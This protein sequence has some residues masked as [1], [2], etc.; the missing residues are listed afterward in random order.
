MLRRHRPQ[1]PASSTRRHL[2]GR[3]TP[4]V[5]A[6]ALALLT[7]CGGGAAVD[8]NNQTGQPNNSGSNS[9]PDPTSPPPETTAR[10]SDPTAWANNTVP[11][12]GQNVLI[13]TGTSM[14]LDVDT[15]ALGSLALEGALVVGDNQ[16]VAITAADVEIRDGGLLQIGSSAEPHTHRATITLT[17]ARGVHVPRSEDN[18]LDND[19]TARGLRVRD[20]GALI[21]V[22]DAPN[23]TK[24]KLN[25]HAN[26]G[27]TTFTLADNVHWRAGDQVAISVT[28]FYGVGETEVL[29]LAADTSG[30]PTMTTTT[31]LQTFRWGR[32]QFPVDATVN[33]SAMSLTQG[34]FTPA[35][36]QTPTQLDE[37]AEVVN[38]SRNIVI[39]GA[40]DGDWSNHGFG[41]HV[42]VMGRQ[43]IAQVDGVEIRRCGQRR[44]VGRYPFHW[45]ML[46]YGGN[47]H[48]RGDAAPG[49]HYLRNASVHASENRAVT[50]HGTCG[51][52]VHDTYAVD[53]LGHA[54]FFEDGPERRNEVS[55]CVAMKVRAPAQPIKQH[56]AAA[57]GFW[58]VN[59]DNTIVRNSA[60]D[61]EGSGLWNSFALSCFGLSRNV[62]I[63]PNSLGIEAFD[64][65]TGH[66]CRQQ[67]IKTADIV[68][69]EAGVTEVAYYEHDL[70]DATM[71]RNIIWK[72]NFGGYSNRVRKPTYV[73]WT[74]ADN[75]GSDFRGAVVR[76]SLLHSALVIGASLNNSTAPPNPHRNAFASYH[77]NIDIVDITAVN[78]PYTGHTITPNGVMVYGGGVLNTGDLYLNPIELQLHRSSGWRLLNSFAG[79]R[80]PPPWFDAY[81]LSMSNGDRHWAMS[82]AMLDAHGY[83]GPAGNYLVAD[84]PFY[85]FGLSSYQMA[86]PGQGNGLS[87]PHRFFGLGS[88]TPGEDG[89]TWSMSCPEEVRM[90]RL[91]SSNNKVGEHII[92]DAGT[93]SFFRFK[94][95]GIQNRGRYRLILPTMSPPDDH[96]N[97]RIDNAWRADDWFIICLPWNGS[98]PV[99]G[100]LNSGN[101]GGGDLST[102][103][104]QGLVRLLNASGTS[105][106]D[107]IAD[108]TGE[109]MWQDSPNDRVWLKYVGGLT[110]NVSNYDGSN[111][112]SLF[113]TQH[114]KL[115][116]P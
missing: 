108:P 56:D 101:L 24:T 86:A 37:R 26:A 66:S 83:W 45:H 19:G 87:T 5:V 82:G 22:G 42:M 109:T 20:G 104:Q 112:E 102:F 98:T 93:A 106:A 84:E 116:R 115:Y 14:L 75:S 7:A 50:V 94:H 88:I 111:N 91:D 41:V 110:L 15:A 79:F 80:T 21:L 3:R 33:G 59:P 89:H 71:R 65:N 103:V 54:F 57:S 90:E 81:P 30:A 23:R 68:S 60:S 77:F 44:A 4:G 113:R 95:F 9:P 8:G 58:L 31:P 25:A 72:N 48:F 53:V 12:A 1:T 62:A 17:G 29:T 73:A 99:A 107:V 13:P 51:V 64:D 63:N 6:L 49:A 11:Q 27:A 18:G 96:F 28:D 36:G 74:A 32:L 55:D 114:M 67:G 78:Y 16:D 40:D 70:G 2:A 39:Q 52:Q 76:E 35:N 10:W 97:F 100:R 105:L 69:N 34:P 47:G 92:G 61:C 85:R 43:S 46:S 38:L